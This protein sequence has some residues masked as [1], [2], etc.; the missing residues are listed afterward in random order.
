MKI[1]AQM[2][3][4]REYTQNP[5]DIESTL[6]KLK[7]MGFDMVQISGFGPCD[8]DILAGWIKELGMEVCGT[9]SPW[10]RIADTDELKKLID[11]H[12]KLGAT[13][14]GL[15]MKPIAIYPDTYEGYTEFIKKVNDICKMLKDNGM[16]FGYHNHE[17]EFQKFNGIRA[18]DRIIEECPDLNFILDIFWAQA[19]GINP[20]TYLNKLKG[21]IKIVHLKD[22]RVIGRTRQFGEIGEGNFDWKEIIPCCEKIGIPYAVI[23]QDGDFLS[24]PFDSLALSRKY[25]LENGYWR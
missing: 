23:E 14:I 19:G 13:E 22:Y 17:L 12:K 20:L 3:T 1:G 6:R 16:T 24:N 7:A 18:I 10:N 9:H 25:L 21:R 11:E 2:F 4:V 8:I 5:K 15:G